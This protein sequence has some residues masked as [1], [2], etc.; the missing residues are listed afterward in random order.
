LE[1]RMDKLQHDVTEV[2]QMV[3]A[4]TVALTG[5]SMN[6]GALADIRDDIESHDKEIH[7]LNVT[8]HSIQAKMF[9][10]QER[11]DIIKFVEFFKG[12]KLVLGGVLY[13]IALATPYIIKT[14]YP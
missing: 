10:A 2:K 11:T 12:W 9:T 8:V 6:K 5:D 1:S 7:D 3:T 4:L 14:L 13:L